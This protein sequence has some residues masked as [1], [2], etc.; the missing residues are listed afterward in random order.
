MEL[1]SEIADMVGMSSLFMAT[2]ANL[3]LALHPCFH[4]HYMPIIASLLLLL[5]GS[6]FGNSAKACRCHCHGSRV[7]VPRIS[8]Y[9]PLVYILDGIAYF[10]TT[11]LVCFPHNLWLE[12]PVLLLLLGSSFGNSRKECHC[13]GSRVVVPAISCDKTLVYMLDG[14]YGFLTPAT[15]P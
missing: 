1:G 6:C 8:C 11:Y 14:L 15:Y 13:H 10:A 9:K 5:L 2:I 7:V 12:Q 4:T 3:S